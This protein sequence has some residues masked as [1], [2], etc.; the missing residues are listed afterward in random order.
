[1]R[2]STWYE[3]AT[4]GARY[5]CDVVTRVPAN[6]I[7]MI[8]DALGG[9]AAPR[10]ALPAMTVAARSRFQPVRTIHGPV[11]DPDA[12]ALPV[13]DPPASAPM[14]AEATVST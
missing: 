13:F 4:S 2:R 10:P 7:M 3:P 8:I 5:T 11:I 1:M 6:P 14:A 9:S 12:A